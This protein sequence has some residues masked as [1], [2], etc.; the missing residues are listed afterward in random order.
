MSPYTPLSPSL[1][2]FLDRKMLNLEMAQVQRAVTG[3]RHS[4]RRRCAGPLVLPLSSLQTS[5]SPRGC[6][7]P[8][9]HANQRHSPQ[10]ISPKSLKPLLHAYRWHRCNTSKRQQ[11]HFLTQH[12]TV[13]SA[14]WPTHT[15]WLLDRVQVLQKGAQESLPVFNIYTAP[16]ST[17]V[18][19]HVLKWNTGA[20]INTKVW[21]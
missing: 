1:I 12:M 19:Q 9:L 14:T 4:C 8:Q 17:K 5:D 16:V 20:R 11:T 10:I 2:C 15:V 21:C 13:Y 7:L 6:S 3:T 18:I